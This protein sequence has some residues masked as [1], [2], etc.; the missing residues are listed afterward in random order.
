MTRARVTVAKPSC[1]MGPP[2]AAP[3]AVAEE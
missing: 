1:R 3:L 2:P